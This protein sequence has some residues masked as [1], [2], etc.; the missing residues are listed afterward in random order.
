MSKKILSLLSI[1]ISLFIMAA[2]SSDKS[3]SSG[4]GNTD[5]GGTG[6]NTTENKKV[7]KFYNFGDSNFAITEDGSLYAWGLND[8]GQLGLGDENN[9]N[10]PTK[11]SGISGKI[12][13][14]SEKSKSIVAITEDGYVY[15]WGANGIGQFGLSGTNNTPTQINNI[16]KKVTKTFLEIIN[17][18]FITEDG[19]LYVA[20][21]CLN[22]LCGTGEKNYY[23]IPEKIN[24]MTGKIKDVIIGKTSNNVFVLMEDGSVYVWGTNMYGNLGI[25]SAQNEVNTPTKIQSLYSV[26]NIIADNDR[27]FAHTADN[28]LFAWGYNEDG[29]L[30]MND[31]KNK[32]VAV[33]IGLYNGTNRYADLKA[34][35][36][37]N[38]YNTFYALAEDGALFSWGFNSEYSELGH[39]EV[40]INHDVYKPTPVH[41]DKGVTV[42]RVLPLS[43]RDSRYVIIQDGSL[44]AWGRNDV[45]QLGMGHQPVENHPI[46]VEGITG[47]DIVDFKGTGEDTES[48]YALMKDGSL[49][50][51][52]GNKYGQLGLGLGNNENK[53]TVSKINSIT[54]KVISLATGKY[55][56]FALTEDGS[57]YA[58]GANSMGQLGVGDTENKNIPTKVIFK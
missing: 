23:E 46:K 5:S 57:L 4:S 28:F 51:W 9:R 40:F 44:Y 21:D 39:E 18:Y 56:V 33:K 10:T 32:A 13:N 53:T 52:G 1:F 55:N 29:L 43:S 37:M 35:D 41:F 27:F 34:A 14:I 24:G 36:F 38:I 25:S 48:I 12:T 3:I 47:D 58:W 16:N 22:T 2:C 45:G 15:A 42:K 6:D 20:G 54:G 17:A 7:T 31:T 50:A 26:D 8:V 11:V 19:A 30:G 49:Y